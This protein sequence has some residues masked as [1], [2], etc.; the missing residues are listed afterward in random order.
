MYGSIELGGTK[1]RCGIF[2]DDGELKDELRIKTTNPDDNIKEA[3]EFLKR[4]D[5]KSLGVGTFG[6]AD[7]DKSSKTYGYILDTPKTLWQNYDLLG[8]LSELNL[9]MGF[10][11]D[12]GASNLGEY[13]LGAGINERSSLYLTIGT[14]VGGAFIQD[15]VLLEGVSHPEMGHIEIAREAD[16]DFTGICPYHD[17]CFEG[18]CCGPAVEKRAGKKPENLDIDDPSLKITAKYIAQAIYDLSVVL[19]PHIVI[20]GGGLINKEGMLDMIRTEFDKL[21]GTY[22]SLP[23]AKDYIVFPK[24]G[25]EAGLVGGYI[26]AKEVYRK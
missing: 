11:S 19:R 18:L 14:G 7:V 5:I 15:G 24:L 16:D 21:K 1:I 25:N 6:P 9:P 20:I 4:F 12:V 26:L 17:S 23:E 22:L 13:H 10:T 3:I 2:S 8:A